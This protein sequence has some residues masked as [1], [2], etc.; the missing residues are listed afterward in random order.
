MNREEILNRISIDPKICFGKPC[1]QHDFHYKR[2]CTN[3]DR[4][5]AD[6]AFYRFMKRVIKTQ[7]WW[8]KP[9]LHFWAGLYYRSVRAFGGMDDAFNFADEMM[10]QAEVDAAVVEYRKQEGR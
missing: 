3:K 1:M 7:P 6:V 4:K 9:D 5:M 2:G 10:T 8:R